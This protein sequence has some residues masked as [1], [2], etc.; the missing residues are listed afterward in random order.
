MS[1]WAPDEESIL[2]YDDVGT[3]GAHHL[4]REPDEDGES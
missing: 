1:D 4:D 2:V 3:A